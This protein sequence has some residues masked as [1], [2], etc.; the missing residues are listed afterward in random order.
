MC[1]KKRYRFKPTSKKK[2]I[3]KERISPKVCITCYIPGYTGVVKA[4]HVSRGCVCG[5]ILQYSAFIHLSN[6]T[7]NIGYYKSQLYVII[8]TA[9]STD[10]SDN[11]Y[12]WNC[13]Q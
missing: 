9:V 8:F 1:K 12:H 10:V 13:F 2:K 11:Q 6:F 5:V 7:L 4:A 3:K